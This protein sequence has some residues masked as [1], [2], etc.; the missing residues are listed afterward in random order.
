MNFSTEIRKELL[1]TRPK[2]E[3]RFALLCG[4]LCVSGEIR[5]G[6]CAFTS[7]NEETAEYILSVFEQLGIRMNLTGAA[8]DPKHGKDKLTFSARLSEECAHALSRGPS[9]LAQESAV[10]YLKGAFLGS[11]SCTLP[12]ARGRGYHLEFVFRTAADAAAFVELLDGLQLFGNIVPRGESEVVYLKSREAIGDLLSVM[13][14]KHALA[15]LEAVSSA[16]EENNR[17]NRLE[18]C[19]AGNADRAATASVVQT[20]AFSELAASGALAALPLPLRNVAEARLAKPEC[21]MSELAQYLGITKSC[22]NHRIRK[23]MQI[24]TERKS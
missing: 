6:E 11:G 23:L 3:A 16:R 22:L 10:A 5:G 12:S 4:F 2:A 13:G 8:R 15:T 24:Y 1:R 7:E 17:E 20:L 14:A 21:S 18:N 9:A 19:T